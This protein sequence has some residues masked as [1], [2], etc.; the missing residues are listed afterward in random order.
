MKTLNYAVVFKAEPEGGYTAVVPS[1]PGCVTYGKNLEEA[2][3]MSK[4][5]INGYLTSLKNHGEEIPSDEQV[6]FGNVNIN[7]KAQPSY[8]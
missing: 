7:Y 3:K 5:A 4:E 8:L 2:K 1:L 6:F